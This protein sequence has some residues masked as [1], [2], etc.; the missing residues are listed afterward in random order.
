MEEEIQNHLHLH[1]QNSKHSLTLVLKVNL[2]CVTGEVIPAKLVEVDVRLCGETLMKRSIGPY[3]VHCTLTY[4]VEFNLKRYHKC[5]S[6][7]K[8]IC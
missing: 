6:N 4:Y 8:N 7:V 2:Q 5:T 3:E 1:R